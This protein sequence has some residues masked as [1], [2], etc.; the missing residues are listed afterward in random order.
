MNFLHYPLNFQEKGVRVEFT[1]NGNSCNV[2]LLDE[3]NFQRY[4]NGTKFTYFGGKATRSPVI[5]TVPESK[6]WHGVVDFGGYRGSSSVSV[7]IIG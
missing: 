1:I 7:R 6:V 4:R 3:S 5:L 2:M